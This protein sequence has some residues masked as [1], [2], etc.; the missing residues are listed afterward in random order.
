KAGAA[1]VFSI[2]AFP[3]NVTNHPTGQT[4]PPWKGLSFSLGMSDGKVIRDMI[5]ADQAPKVHIELA[6]ESRE[7][8]TTHSVWGVLPG[9]TNENILIMAH[10]ETF[11]EG[12]SDNASGVATM[13]ELAR[14]YASMPKAQR[15]RTI[16]FLTTS[17]HHAPCPNG[18][19]Q[20]VRKN[21]DSFFA[22][23]AL[24]AN[25]EHTAMMQAY[26][27]G[28]NLVGSN[29]VA[30][31]RWYMQ[32]SDDLKKIVTAAFREFGVGTD[33]RPAAGSGGELG[34]L[35]DKAPGSHV[36]ADIW[37]HT[38]MDKPATVPE[39]GVEST[40]RAY[41]KVIDEANKLDLKALR[42]TEY[43]VAIK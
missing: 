26:Y 1:A 38:D 29:V 24:I 2:L 7:N 11:F 37:Y 14:F 27:I 43:P 5:E 36:L 17:C 20:W 30:A 16:T 28:P 19:I 3:G 34:S 42:G 40:V 13:I 8:L 9:M 31:H 33:S 23:T 41:A 22:K 10:T 21:M 39:A 15:R 12:A 25:C 6:V 35:K 32:G 18:G 4:P